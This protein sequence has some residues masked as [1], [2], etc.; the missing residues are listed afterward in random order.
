VNLSNKSYEGCENILLE[1]DYNFDSLANKLK[2]ISNH[3]D[4][5]ICL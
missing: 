2:K 3:Y 1:E 5:I 4:C